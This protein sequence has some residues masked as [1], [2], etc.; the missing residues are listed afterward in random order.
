MSV[1]S[2]PLLDGDQPQPIG[3][4]VTSKCSQ[5]RANTGNLHRSAFMNLSGLTCVCKYK[6]FLEKYLGLG[7]KKPK[8]KAFG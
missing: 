6:L 7:I 1:N 4:L 5:H 8:A 2:E 3:F